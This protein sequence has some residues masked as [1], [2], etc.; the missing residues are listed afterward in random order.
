MPAADVAFNFAGGV[1]VQR[2]SDP[3]ESRPGPA[4]DPVTGTLGAIRLS[5][6]SR[7]P[8][9]HL[10]EVGAAVA[11]DGLIIRIGYG[12]RVY[13]D[14]TVESLGEDLI[15]ALTEFARHRS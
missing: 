1:S 13:R 8:R 11:A 15:T 9:R 14:R 4:A 7:G 2:L 5:E 10:L 6:S 12:S 3:G